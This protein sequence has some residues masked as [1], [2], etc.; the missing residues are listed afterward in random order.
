MK[1]EIEIPKTA[2]V[3]IGFL[4]LGVVMLLSLALISCGSKEEPVKNSEE[5]ANESND[6]KLAVPLI[7]EA[8]FLVNAA[9]ISL[10]EIQLGQLA[11]SNGSIEEVKGLGKMMEKEHTEMLK[12][13]GTLAAKKQITLPKSLTGTELE[14]Y[15]KLQKLAGVDFD[16]EY[17]AMM[18][19][20][21]QDAIGKFDKA[22]IET[23]DADIKSWTE[24]NLP[25][26][27]N[28]LDHAMACQAKVETK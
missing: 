14:E 27:R 19:K 26:L 25:A 28:H 23:Y 7:T 3:T 21:H 22:S 4:T 9:I 11:Q 8:D 20:G 10:K 12:N 24:S 17:C 6:S 15:E 5:I 1:N 18:V 13:L 16:K 2:I